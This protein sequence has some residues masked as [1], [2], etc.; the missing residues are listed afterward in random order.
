[1]GRLQ[2]GVG[3]V[4]IVL[5]V[6]LGAALVVVSV[7]NV[8]L[9]AEAVRVSQPADGDRVRIAQLT[10][11][12]SI[13]TD[14]RPAL[15]AHVLD[16]IRGTGGIEA[17]ALAT[18]LPELGRPRS[19]LTFAA[20]GKET[21]CS[22][23]V[24]YVS[25]EFFSALGLRFLKGKVESGPSAIVSAS[26][27]SRCFEERADRELQVHVPAGSALSHH[28]I[29]VSGVVVDPFR[30]RMPGTDVMASYA[31]IV[32]ALEW[33][34]QV[35]V[36]V[37]AS[38]G[39]KAAAMQPV[40][41]VVLDAFTPMADRIGPGNASTR[42]ILT[43]SGSGAALALLL[44]FLG[45]HAAMSQS[46][47]RRMRELGIRLALGA[48]PRRLVSTALVHDAPLVVV[49]L[50]VGLAGTLWVTVIVW[51][52]LLIFNAIDVRV[53]ASI[54]AVL[55]GAALLA[56]LGPALRAVRVDPIALLHTE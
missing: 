9:F 44:A 29:P 30:S 54:G 38:T 35:S 26:A 49:G 7:F 16:A 28:W 42:L 55:A 18:A 43:V 51:R 52:D 50:V 5:Q 37:R 23:K 34:A 56:S 22:I 2:Y 13:A 41:G 31:W 32:G 12:R 19:S 8:R 21:R 46:C 40:D 25:D 47:E 27:A 39:P 20:V 17:V 1:M 53:W 24:A 3:D 6:A 11:A 48:P 4:L 45:V 10:A 14:A 36:V 33:P 15:F